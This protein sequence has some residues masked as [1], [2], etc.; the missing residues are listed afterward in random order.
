M[1]R[2]DYF[3]HPEGTGGM[4]GSGTG[5]NED[6][7]KLLED[8]QAWV[9]ADTLNRDVRQLLGFMLFRLDLIWLWRNNS[10]PT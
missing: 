8:L 10:I 1:Y 2:L 3:K 5:L 4:G 6:Q 9:D 7:E